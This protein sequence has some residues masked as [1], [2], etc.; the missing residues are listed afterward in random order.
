MTSFPGRIKRR[1]TITGNALLHDTP[2]QRPSDMDAEFWA[3]HQQV[4]PYT[5]TSPERLF[6]LRDAA[7]YIQR[8]HIPGDFVECGVWRGGSTMMAAL[9]LKAQPRRLW[10]YDTF[11]GMVEP[12]EYDFDLV[13]VHAGEEWRAH[14]QDGGWAVAALDD[15]KSHIAQTAYDPSLVTYV[16]GKVEDTIPNHLPEEVAILRLDTDW[17]ESTRHELQHLWPLLAPGGVLIVDDYGHYQ[18][19]RKAV[20]EFFAGLASQPLLHRVDYTGRVA[21]KR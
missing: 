5:M 8:E 13:G 16:Q 7:L 6:A 4:A 9:V 2:P 15:V 21:I 18:G 1:L 10:L 3:L 17:Y 12:G 11:E 19:A 14:E 20:D